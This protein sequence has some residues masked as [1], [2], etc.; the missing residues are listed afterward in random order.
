VDVVA[1]LPR[2]LLSHL[3]IVLGS[4]HSLIVARRWED[5]RATILERIPDTLVVDPLASGEARVDVIEDLHREFPSLPI[6]VYTVLSA[7]S[8]RA[9]HH[10]GRIGIEHV[11]LNRFED[12][13]RRFLDLLE[14][15][16]GQA[17]SDDMLRSLSPELSRLPVAMV[18]AIEQL[19]RSP[20]RFRTAKD[21]AVAAGA[22][23]R[24]LYRQLETSGIRSPRLL[25]AAARLLRAYALLRDPARQ[26]KE[27]ATKV[28][29]HSHYQ[30]T[31]HMRTM[32]GFTPRSVRINI[33]PAQF[34]LLLADG[35]RHATR[36]RRV[37]ARRSS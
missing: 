3:T 31:Q 6:V 2:Q 14:R 25:V 11:V 5:L 35:V 34:V 27:V 36:S 19:F 32:T 24:T 22:I 26:I 1:Y 23:E 12:E 16:P 37:H 29:Y 10:L 13:R 8:M 21:L 28:G 20:A 17:L 30:L 4:Q 15:V 33:E 9:I 7:P 18:R